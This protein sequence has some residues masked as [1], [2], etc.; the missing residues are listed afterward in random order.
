MKCECHV[1]SGY[2]KFKEMINGVTPEQK[3]YF[4]KLFDN[5][6]ETSSDLDYYKVLV[7]GSWDM[8]DDIIAR[9]RKGK[10]K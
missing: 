6:T 7:D 3:L 8:A 9:I 2:S 5:F 4:E 1:C 10:L